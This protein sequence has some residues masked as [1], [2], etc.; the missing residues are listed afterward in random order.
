MTCPHC[1]SSTN[2]SGQCPTCGQYVGTSI[3]T[4]ETAIMVE[5]SEVVVPK[6]HTKDM[7]ER[8]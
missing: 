8:S 2:Y 3:K 4:T 1:D 5:H 7:R 6:E